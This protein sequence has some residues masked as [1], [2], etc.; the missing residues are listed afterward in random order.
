MSDAALDLAI[1]GVVPVRGSEV[2]VAPAV[3]TIGSRRV[4]VRMSSGLS[5]LGRADLLAFVRGADAIVT[6]FTD[7]VDDEFLDAAG[8][9]L[10]CVCNFAVGTDNID[11]AACERRGVLVRNTP[12]VVTEGT[13]N[14]AMG[15]ILACSRRIVQADAYVRSGRFSRDGNTF[16]TGWMGMDLCGRELLIVGA[17]RIGYA[18]A[19]RALAFGMRIAYTSRSRKLNFEIAPVAARRVELDEGL[20][21]ADVVSVHTPLTPETRGLIDARRLSLLRPEAILVN[22]ARGAVIDEAALASVLRRGRI[23]GAGL[24]VFEREPAVH[25]DLLTLDNVV[26]TPHMGSAE[27]R[28]REE[29]TIVAVESAMEGWRLA[30]GGA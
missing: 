28:W 4:N 1:T 24:D 2:G 25:P 7:R 14:L 20:A 21:C 16:P 11:F 30:T 18:V 15:L 29:M 22:T 10:R 5:P 17:G 19:Q 26:M 9:R 13:A 23:W 27:R 12:D 3:A 8:P 6:M